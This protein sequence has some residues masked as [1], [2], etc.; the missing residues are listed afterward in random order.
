MTAKKFEGKIATVNPLP[1]EKLDYLVEVEFTNSTND[2]LIG[3]LARV[4][5]MPQ[6]VAGGK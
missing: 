1:T 2:L 4:Q 5:F 3:Q 6:T